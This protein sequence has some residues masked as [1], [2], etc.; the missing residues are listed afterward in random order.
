MS[1]DIKRMSKAELEHL[2]ELIRQRKQSQNPA[3]V[4][5][6]TRQ[7]KRVRSHDPQD[8][9]PGLSSLICF[10]LSFSGVNN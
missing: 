9:A 10:D 1:Q 2:N 6:P 4:E 5:E 3:N 8:Y 7:A